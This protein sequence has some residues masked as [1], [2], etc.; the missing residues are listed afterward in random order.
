MASW[1]VKIHLH[2]PP[3]SQTPA[4]ID[5]PQKSEAEQE[6]NS[7][8]G[9]SLLTLVRNQYNYGHAFQIVGRRKSS[10]CSYLL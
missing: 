6:K 5:N 1:F 10:V 2:Q 9:S 3:V 7:A 4:A 8:N